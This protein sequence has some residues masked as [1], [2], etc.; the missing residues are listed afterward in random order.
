MRAV[1]KERE[2][3]SGGSSSEDRRRLLLEQL[4]LLETTLP[5][6]AAGIV[7]LLISAG[8]LLQGAFSTT[9]LWSW[10]AA[11][12]LL[13]ALRFASVSLG[14]STEPGHEAV[15]AR[16]FAG[17]AHATSSGMLWGAMG[18]MGVASPDPQATLIVIMMLTGLVGGATALISHL[19][20]VFIPYVVPMILP[21]A[22]YLLIS[23]DAPPEQRWIGVLL[24]LYLLFLLM[25]ARAVGRAVRQAI[26]LRFRNADLV[27]G[28]REANDD[29]DEQR[30]RAEA[31][32]ERERAANLAKSRF[33]AA[34]SHDLRQPLHSLRLHIATLQSQTRESPHEDAVRLMGHSV[35]ALDR[36]FD[37]ILDIS[38]LDAGTFEPRRVHVPLLPLLERLVQEFTPLAVERGLVLRLDAV[39]T[40]IHS[41]PMLLER[42]LRNLLANA[43]RYTVSGGVRM[44]VDDGPLDRVRLRVLDT[45]PGIA[46]GDRARVFEEF[47][48]L[49]NPERDR[50]QGIGLG[51]S[52]VRRIVELLDLPLE[53]GETPGG[54]T[55]VTLLI[56]PGRVPLASP[57]GA[58]PIAERDEAQQLSL[59]VMVVDDEEGIRLAMEGFLVHHGCL[60]L[61]VDSGDQAIA[62]LV[63]TGCRPDAVVCDYRLRRDERGTAVVVRIREHCGRQVP[64][65]LVTGDTGVDDLRDLRLS[66]LQVLHKPCDPATLLQTLADVCGRP[67]DPAPPRNPV[68]ISS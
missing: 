11:Q 19:P 40:M 22:L 43:L 58:A 61:A 45:G 48:Q 33:L 44:V 1:M 52:I 37:S 24:S 32:L 67:D 13:L 46:P 39:D 3:S 35:H 17:M 26:K 16:L 6:A 10:L 38:R 34:A 2:K 56:P 65:I 68:T 25:A 47:V 60:V 20:Q 31:A 50:S 4:R 66:A 7:V 64:A 62:T 36:L 29:A 15:S 57:S 28:L 23:G 55:T 41:D 59:T 18:Y 14:R 9:F 63:E 49:G 51:L 8:V 53:L 12:S 5:S 27:S 42:V 54:G 30:R 21:A